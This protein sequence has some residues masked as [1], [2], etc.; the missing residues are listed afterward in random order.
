MKIFFDICTGGTLVV[1]FCGFVSTQFFEISGKIGWDF[2]T[3]WVLI[4]LLSILYQILFYFYIN[5]IAES[6]KFYFKMGAKSVRAWEKTKRLYFFGSS[7]FY[8]KYVR[9]YLF[10]Q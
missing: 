1:I 9:E 8:Y 4:N 5:S 10:G 6:A 2:A 7:I 3:F